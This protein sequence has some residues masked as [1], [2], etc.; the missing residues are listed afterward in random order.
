METNLRINAWIHTIAQ[1]STRFRRILTAA[2]VYLLL[3][4]NSGCLSLFEEKKLGPYRII[5]LKINIINY[6]INFIIIYL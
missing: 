4:D 3:K 2:A 5:I 1:K 6:Y